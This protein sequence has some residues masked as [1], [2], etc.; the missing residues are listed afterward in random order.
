MLEQSEIA[1]D[2]S[3]D[4]DQTARSVQCDP[5]SVLIIVETK[6]QYVDFF[7]LLEKLTHSLSTLSDNSPFLEH[8]LDL[9]ANLTVRPEYPRRIPVIKKVRR[10]FKISYNC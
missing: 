9:T 6:Y 2:D 8:F 10:Y 3:A 5:C 4:Q 1:F 7:F